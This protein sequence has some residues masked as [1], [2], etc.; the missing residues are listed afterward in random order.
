MN[1]TK[2]G[3]NVTVH[4]HATTTPKATNNPNVCTGGM[5]ARDSDANPTAVVREVYSMGSIA[6]TFTVLGMFVLRLI[7][8]LAVIGLVAYVFRQ[9]DLRWQK[10]A[11]AMQRMGIE[12]GD[13][14]GSGVRW[15]EKLYRP[16]WEEKGCD[17]SACAKCPAHRQSSLPCWMARRWAEGRVPAKCYK[18]ERFTLRPA[19]VPVA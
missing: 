7:V 1:I 5:G 4:I 19:S 6:G 8:P 15:L 9:I 10:E 18:C 11:W 2:A 17:E 14:D 12:Q 16:C 13:S 3:M